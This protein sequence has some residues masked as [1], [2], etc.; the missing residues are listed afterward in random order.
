MKS[1][2][3]LLSGTMAALE[4]LNQCRASNVDSMLKDIWNETV[5]LHE[6]RYD[7]AVYVFTVVYVLLSLFVLKALVSTVAEIG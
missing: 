2:F 5:E 6:K 7:V 3:R 4:Y 1:T